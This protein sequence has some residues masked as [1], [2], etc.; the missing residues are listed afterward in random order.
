MPFSAFLYDTRHPKRGVRPVL[1]RL[2]IIEFN[3]A[4]HRA[5][6]RVI[7]PQARPAYPPKISSAHNPEAAPVTVSV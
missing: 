2:Y 1:L 7:M 4:V 6:A 5:I 3:S